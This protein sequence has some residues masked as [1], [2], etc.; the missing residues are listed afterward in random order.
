MEE[1]RID[2][3]YNKS[4]TY[5]VVLGVGLYLTG[6]GTDTHGKAFKRNV[7]RDITRLVECLHF[8]RSDFDKLGK[9]VLLVI[10]DDNSPTKVPALSRIF[11]NYIIVA[12]KE[13]QGIGQKENLLETIATYHAKY[14]FRIDQDVMVTES[15]APMF[16]AF[17]ENKNLFCAGLNS[18]WMGG[19]IE[20]NNPLAKYVD[21]VQL[22]NC[23]L[24]DTSLFHKVG[25]TDPKLKYFHDLDLFYRAKDHGFNLVMAMKSKG[26][27]KSSR[28]AGTMS[29]EAM[30]NEAM[31]LERSNPSLYFYNNKEGKPIIRYEKLHDVRTFFPREV[32]Y[33]DSSELSLKILQALKYYEKESY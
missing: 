2:K 28:A 3:S 14:L 4:A 32:K 12:L 9:S 25:F 6:L 13:N 1:I 7:A 26:V 20:L 8:L 22:G 19:M 24:E 27:T 11:K 18:G 17:E 29:F 15:V 16:L 30:Q 31:Y 23:V 5:D 21:T 33:I 10:V